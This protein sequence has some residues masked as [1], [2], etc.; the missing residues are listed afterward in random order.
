MQ[1]LGVMRGDFTESESRLF[2]TKIT[3]FF[4]F[5][6]NMVKLIQTNI[7]SYH[8]LKSVNKRKNSELNLFFP[9]LLCRKSPHPFLC[10]LIKNNGLKFQIDI[11]KKTLIRT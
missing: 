5:F 7:L 9:S 8:L 4:L 11:L 3:Y 6:D 10:F 2:L 1:L